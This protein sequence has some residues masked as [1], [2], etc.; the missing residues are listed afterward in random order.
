[1]ASAATRVDGLTINVI[2]SANSIRA[3]LSNGN[4]L[5]SGAV[6]PPGLYSVI[7]YDDSVDPTPMFTMTG[8]GA[9]VSSDLNPNGMG[10]E[11]PVTLGPFVLVASSSYTISD[12]NMGGGS[13]ISFTTA[14]TG[15]SSS[16][17]SSTSLSAGSSA[18]GSATTKTVTTLALI[19]LPSG[20]PAIT[21]GGK[22]VMKLAAGRYSVVVSDL[23]K[24]AGLVLGHGVVRPVTLS[25]AAA[26]GTSE[27]T[28]KLTAGK[29]FLETSAHGP[30][31]YFTVG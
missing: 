10:I 4:A 31:I 16:P 20:K 7:V 2:Y 25:S 5:T 24:K 3:N 1:M 14:A 27:R 18:P 21:F 22:A 8:P 23:S 28:L 9:E 26:V 30:K 13:A 12:S 6:L 19:A 15:S 11:V 29:W 17:N